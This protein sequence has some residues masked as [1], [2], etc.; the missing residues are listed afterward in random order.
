M[1]LSDCP[2]CW[3]TPCNCGWEWKD[4]TIPSLNWYIKMLSAIKEYKMTHLGATFSWYCED[5]ETKDDQEI[6]KKLNKL[7]IEH[8]NIKL[9]GENSD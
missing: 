2:K 7:Y 8:F 4:Y 1:A 5:E 9:K 6:M 3:N